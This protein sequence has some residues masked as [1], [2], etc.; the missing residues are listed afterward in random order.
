MIEVVTFDLDD[1]LW[2]IRAVIIKAEAQTQDWLVARVPLY[3]ERVT[4]TTMGSLRKAL[5]AEQPQLAFNISDLRTELL[6]VSIELC[7]VDKARAR[8]LADGAFEV[9]MLGR[10]RVELYADALPVLNIL[11]QNY[12]LGALTNGNA[13]INRIG[14][15]SHFE[16][17]ISPFEAQAR[18]PAAAIF[19][20]TL[21][22]AGCAREAIVHVGDHPIEDIGGAAAA[23]W[24]S[25]WVNLKG[26]I[27][28]NPPPFTAMVTRLAELPDAIDAISTGGQR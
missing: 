8:D 17:S 18:K 4:Q 9:F 19:D 13:D 23:G 1:T 12:R 7:D 5:L 6:R 22:R 26:A 14:L 2:P 25:I 16:F 11:K 21:A 3:P 28:D 24:H 20:V 15:T 10:N 27:L